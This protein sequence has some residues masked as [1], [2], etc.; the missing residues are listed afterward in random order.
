MTDI[1]ILIVEDEAIVAEDLASHLERLGY[2]VADIVD[3]GEDAIAVATALKPNL[4]LM[5]IRLAGEMDGTEA[6]RQIY[7]NSNI[8]AVYLT[9]YADDRTLERVKLTNPFGYIQKP[10]TS[11]ELRAAIEIAL[12]RHQSEVRAKQTLQDARARQEEAQT[13]SELK[14]QYLS[15]ASREIRAPL[16]T[17]ESVASVLE[18]RGHTLT[19]EKVRDYLHGIK[20]VVSD[21]NQ[22]M[23][24]LLFLE[25]IASPDLDLKLELF[26]VVA[27]CQETIDKLNHE[28]NDWKHELILASDLDCIEVN[29]DRQFLQQILNNLLANA[30]AYSPPESTV[31]LKLSQ[32]ANRLVLQVKDRGAGIPECDRATLFDPFQRG[33]NMERTPSLGLGL[34]IVKQLV[35]RCR[36]E[37]RY[38]SELGQGTTFEISIPVNWEDSKVAPNSDP[39]TTGEGLPK[40]SLRQAIEYIHRHLDRD[41]KLPDL[42]AVT[43]MSQSHFARLFKQALGVTLRQYIIQQ[44]IERSKHLL[45]QNLHLQ[46]A[47]IAIQCGFANQIH[48]TKSFRQITGITPK[49]YREQ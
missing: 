41:L 12:T 11:Q 45:K 47:D 49:A 7:A 46:I 26:N 33:S 13:D 20:E 16:M 6:T 18:T 19:E 30:I 3:S 25:K 48:F 1:K 10:F 24:K 21:V 34:A 23:E 31:W 44:R 17:I 40:W 22:L 35:D 36:G 42:A 2:V 28:A 29:L 9:A 15:I 37:I 27:F 39:V 32:I 8:P 14:S 5:D 4:V 43:G 38:Q